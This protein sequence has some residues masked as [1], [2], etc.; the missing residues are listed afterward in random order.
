MTTNPPID[1]TAAERANQLLDRTLVKAFLENVPDIVYFKDRE[2]RFIAVSRSKAKRHE[3]EPADLLGKTD[4]DFFS[5]QH[6]QQARADEE[7]I[8]ATGTPVLGKL[9]RTQF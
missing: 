8:M 9:E 4:A 1:I 5:E 6:A 7:K 2:S 3:L